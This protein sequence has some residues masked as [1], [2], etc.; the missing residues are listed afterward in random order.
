M[1]GVQYYPSAVVLP[2]TLRATL[3]KPARLVFGAALVLAAAACTRDITNELVLPRSSL[4]LWGRVVDTAGA[5]IAG[6][7]V[8]LSYHPFL[9]SVAAR[10]SAAV[11][12]GSDGRYRAELT[13]VAEDEGCLRLRVQ[14]SGFMPDSATRLDGAFR[15]QPPLD[16]VQ[17][18]FTLRPR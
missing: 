11:T 3:R 14:A 4:I 13:V 10:G 6:A 7:R 5:G 9:C 2:P 16:S 18:N 1:P 8:D 12:T 17:T 15:R